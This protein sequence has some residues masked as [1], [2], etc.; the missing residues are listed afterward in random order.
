M[1]LTGMRVGEVG[2]LMWKDVDF[3][4]K[5]INIKR[6]LSCQYEYGEKKLRL[7]TP[8]THN[9]YRTIPFF[10]EAEEMFLAQQQKIIELKKN[11]GRRWRA[12]GEYS[13]LVFVTSM[14]SP[15]LRYHA[16]KEIKKVVKEINE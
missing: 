12:Q 10:G 11:L 9:F 4:N 15:I 14:G 6:S 13:D 3:D 5:C 1:F 2:G 7:M 8:K 16:E